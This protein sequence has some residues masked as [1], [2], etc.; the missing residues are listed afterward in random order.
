MKLDKH[1]I[2]IGFM[3]TG[4]TTIGQ[5]L[6]K[7][8]NCN[9]VDIDQEIV[10]FEGRSINDIFA[11]SGEMYFRK[12]ETET[13]KKTLANISGVVA[14]GGGIILSKENR[15]IISEGQTIL[16]E[17]SIEEIYHRLSDNSDRPLLKADNI[18]EVKEK[19]EK[20]LRERKGLYHSLGAVTINTDNKTIS[21]IV[22]E[23]IDVCFT[24]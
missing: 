24:V 9:F 2:L 16:L 19:M 1:I 22:N 15:Q 10:E 12:I 11:T 4:K 5:E 23:I 3:G 8:L 18:T 6:A 21:E 7:R 14:T 20:L 17:A 13:L